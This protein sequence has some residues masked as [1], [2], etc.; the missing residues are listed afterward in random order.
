MLYNGISEVR[1][2]ERTIPRTIKIVPTLYS[3][4]KHCGGREF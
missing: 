3:Y 2:S 4:H 1:G